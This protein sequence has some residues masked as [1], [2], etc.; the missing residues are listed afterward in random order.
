MDG[1]EERTVI[2]YS[3]PLCAPCEALKRY[4][5]DRGIPFTARDVMVDAEAAERLESL[6]IFT[7][8]ALEVDGQVYAG[9]ALGRDRLDKLLGVG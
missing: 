8:P 5:K 2:V 6:G 7:A 9:P 3:T 4:L 1:T